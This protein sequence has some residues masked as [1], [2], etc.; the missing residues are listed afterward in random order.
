M[1]IVLLKGGLGN[2]LFQICLYLKI[3]KF[4]K[5]TFIEHKLGFLLDYKY[6]RNFELMEI[7]NNINTTGTL[8]S[9]SLL[10]VYSLRKLI[11]ILFKF[12]PLKIIDDNNANLK[13]LNKNNFLS[14]KNFDEKIRI[15]S[16]FDFRICDGYF[17][18]F[19]IVDQT[20]PEL[21]K[22]VNPY[23]NKKTD[24][25][26]NILY[27]LIN[28]KKNSVALCI[29]FY[30][31]SKDPKAHSFKGLQKS[32]HDF[33]KI[34]K[35]TE[36]ELKNPFF[37]IFVQEEN[38]FTS[39]LKFNSPYLFISHKKGFIGSWERLKAQSLC[40]HHIFN[41]S[42]FYWWGCMF[43]KYRFANKKNCKQKVYIADNFIFKEIYDE[44][45]DKF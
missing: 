26:F 38:E 2:Q 21:I 33:N 30:E 36:L 43:S 6:R 37:L 4:Q 34:I 40:R 16:I 17:Q 28:S 32:V 31:E 22:L 15:E 1:N 27:K 44:S 9:I 19:K 20:F 25:Q 8:L 12:L 13:N 14:N 39:K 29:R 10:F 23:L 11:P 35:K 45:W 7:K 18:N 41:N 5:R 42:T 24:E 3:K